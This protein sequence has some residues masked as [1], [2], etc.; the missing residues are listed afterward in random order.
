VRNT[1]KSSSFT[2]QGLSVFFSVSSLN[3]HHILSNASSDADCD[4]DDDD[5]ISVHSESDVD[6]MADWFGE[7]QVNDSWKQPSKFKEAVKIEVCSRFHSK[8]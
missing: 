7:E 6:T 2:A 8:F 1:D 4:K 3:H 5:P